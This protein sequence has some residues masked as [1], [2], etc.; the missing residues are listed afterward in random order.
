[1]ETII[2]NIVTRLAKA[3]KVAVLTGAGISAESGVPTFRGKDGLWNKYDPTE[4]ATP[5]AFAR[6]PRLVWEW[7]Q[8]RRD[9]LNKVEPNAGHYALAELEKRYSLFTLTTQNVDGLHGRAG[10][11]QVLELHGNITKTRCNTCKHLSDFDRYHKDGPL[12]RCDCAGLLRPDVVWFGEALPQ[13]VYETSLAA[14]GMSDVYMVIGTSSLVYPAAYLPQE[15]RAN[16]ACVI[17]INT[18]DTALTPYADFAVRG[19]SGK[20][21]PEIVNRLTLIGIKYA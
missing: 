4:L 16:G 18:Q 1:M 7:Y 21:L 17:E 12:P 19:K 9:L 11:T 2:D 10:S 13:D 20:I 14:A 15:A 5:E 8:Y 6:D 3:N